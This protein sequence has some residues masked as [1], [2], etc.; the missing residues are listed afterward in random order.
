MTNLGPT[1]GDLILYAPKVANLRVGR[2]IIGP[3]FTL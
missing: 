3:T 1:S 2:Y